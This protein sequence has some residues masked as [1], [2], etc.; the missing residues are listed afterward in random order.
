MRS[1]YLTLTLDTEPEAERV[2]RVLTEG[3]EIFMKMEK[4]PSQ[5]DSRCCGIGSG[6]PGCCS[7]NPPQ[8]LESAIVLAPLSIR[9]G[10]VVRR[11]TLA[12]HQ[13]TR[14][15]VLA[16]LPPKWTWNTI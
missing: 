15:L 1:A 7:I 9:P 10:G 12:S 5:T 11:R 6:R 2:Y 16:R 14:S 13:R 8:I 3:G 4:T